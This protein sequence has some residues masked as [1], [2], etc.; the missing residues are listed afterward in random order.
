MIFKKTISVVPICF[1]LYNYK[2]EKI[3]M[4][5]DNTQVIRINKYWFIDLLKILMNYM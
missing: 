3:S 5:C 2:S 1:G 4:K